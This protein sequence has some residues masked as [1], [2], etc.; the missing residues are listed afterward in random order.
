MASA[1][2]PIDLIMTIGLSQAIRTLPFQQ[3]AVM[4]IFLSLLIQGHEF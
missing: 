4:L 1:G 3:T 2:S